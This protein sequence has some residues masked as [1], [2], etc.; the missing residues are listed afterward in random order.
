MRA[1]GKCGVLLPRAVTIKFAAFERSTPFT[2]IPVMGLS[3]RVVLW[4][5]LH[6]SVYAAAGERSIILH[7]YVCPDTRFLDVT[8]IRIA[9]EG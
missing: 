4:V 5:S 7:M 2:G 9:S 6:I 8:M 3:L 1:Y